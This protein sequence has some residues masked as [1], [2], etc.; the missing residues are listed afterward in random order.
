MRNII[1]LLLLLLIPSVAFGWETD[2]EAY[3]SAAVS[4]SLSPAYTNTG[5]TGD[6]TSVITVTVASAFN[7]HNAVSQL[8][9][10]IDDGGTYYWDSV[11]YAADQGV[12]FDFGSGKDVLI[13]EAKFYQQS[14]TSHGTWKW[15]GSDDASDWTDIGS[16][17]TLG[18]EATQTITELSGNSTEYRYYRIL[19]T[20]GTTSNS[21]YQYEFEFKIDGY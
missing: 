16:T 13:T 19:M 4:G 11:G 17:F 8:V 14:A 21:P 2:D 1:F 3:Q 9:D 18:S 5:G 7:P 10:G 20:A 6:R 12:Q 15:Q